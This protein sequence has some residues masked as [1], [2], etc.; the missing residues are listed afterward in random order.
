MAEAS[1]VHGN[2]DGVSFGA[3]NALAQRHIGRFDL[4]SAGP[5]VFAGRYQEHDAAC[6]RRRSHR[7]QKVP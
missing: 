5:E 1:F 4:C 7:W 6:L 3:G 2:A